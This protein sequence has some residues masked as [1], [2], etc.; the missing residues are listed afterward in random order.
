MLLFPLVLCLVLAGTARA[1]ETGE[2]RI[3]VLGTNGTVTVGVRHTYGAWWT[4]GQEQW[5]DKNQQDEMV[6]TTDGVHWETGDAGPMVTTY[7]DK[8]GTHADIRAYRGCWDG[9]R[10][11]VWDYPGGD[12]PSYASA[13]GIHWT[14]WEGRPAI[15]CPEGAAQL[16]PYRFE[17]DP[18]GYTWLMDGE[19]NGLLLPDVKA[20]PYMSITNLQAYYGPNDTVTLEVYDRYEESGNGD[21][22]AV[23]SYATSSLDWCLEHL[24]KPRMPQTS[25]YY[26][27]TLYAA[28]NGVILCKARVGESGAEYWTSADGAH[29]KPILDGPWP[30]YDSASRLLPFNG[31]TF[32]VL[33]QQRLTLY[34]SEDGRHWR[35]LE[36]TF[37][38]PKDSP[39][40]TGAE[41]QFLWTGQEYLVRSRISEVRYGIMG[42]WGGEWYSPYCTKVVFCDADFREIRSYDFGR[43]VEDIAF[44]DGV[45]YAQ[46]S[47][48]MGV[49]VWEYDE[50][51]GASIYSSQDGVGWTATALTRMPG[52]DGESVRAGAYTF[53]LRGDR[54]VWV[55]QDGENYGR[56]ADLPPAQDPQQPTG[57]IDVFAGRDGVLVIGVYPEVYQNVLG[58]GVARI[59]TGAVR[60]Y[61]G[62]ELA[63]AAPATG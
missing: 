59:P 26:W 24:A 11:L 5:Y 21:W 55:S 56:L 2:S 42:T 8:G 47:N 32:L 18:G 17:L 62:A 15:P 50:Y 41:Y 38:T 3:K 28:G 54:E 22:K 63:A 12:D 51:A 7:T 60:S 52:R 19:G 37:L 27:Q 48:S 49:S 6:Y 16:G 1:V 45:C 25:G 10:F 53:Q 14:D 58:E 4:D 35:S 31:K 23:Y 29:W 44:V 43:Q 34:A 20:A 40:H 13:D 57:S 61:S 39:G 46:V 36:D 9:V 30:G 33:D